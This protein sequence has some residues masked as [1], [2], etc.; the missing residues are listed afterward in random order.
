MAAFFEHS[1]AVA[2]PARA[3]GRR[4][5][6]DIGADEQAV[7]HDAL[8]LVEAAKG[9]ALYGALSFVL[10]HALNA[11]RAKRGVAR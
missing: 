10:A 9:H 4:D 3:L 1:D 8:S 5:A 2:A 7:K 11:F 6:L